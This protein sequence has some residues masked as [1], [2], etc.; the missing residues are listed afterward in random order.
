MEVYKEEKGK[1]KWCIYQ[2][3][4]EVQ[5]QFGRKISQDVNGNRKLSWKEVNNANGGKVDNSKIIKDGNGRSTLEKAEYYKD[6]CN[7]DTQE[8]VAVHFCGLDEV[9]RGNYFE[10]EPIRRK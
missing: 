2:S 4:K 8:Q 5:E 9:R 7:I 1:I 6:L 3:K 10:E